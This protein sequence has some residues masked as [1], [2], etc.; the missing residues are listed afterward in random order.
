MIRTK[1]PG[2]KSERYLF[3]YIYTVDFELH[4][5]QQHVLQHKNRRFSQRAPHQQTITSFVQY[6]KITTYCCIYI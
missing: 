1:S 4:Y 6:I 2:M 5:I 3:I